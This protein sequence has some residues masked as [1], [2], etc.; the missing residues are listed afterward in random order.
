MIIGFVVTGISDLR[1]GAGKL[2]GITT[3]IAY[4]STVIAG[5]LSYFMAI[6]IFPKIL[7]FAS[8]AAVEKPEKNLLTP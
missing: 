3:L 5:T 2:L 8:F 7:N 6:T 1:H 4:I